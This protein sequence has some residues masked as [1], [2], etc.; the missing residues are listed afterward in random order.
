METVEKWYQITL[1]YIGRKINLLPHVAIISKSALGFVQESSGGQGTGTWQALHSRVCPVA[2][3]PPGART[4]RSLLEEVWAP[5]DHL[6]KPRTTSS[7]SNPAHPEFS[8]IQSWFSENHTWDSQL[9][10][11][12]SVCVCAQNMFLK[13]LNWESLNKA[14]LYLILPSFKSQIP[15]NDI[16]VS[17]L[18]SGQNKSLG[19]SKSSF[20]GSETSLV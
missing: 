7:P 1:I 6:G 5:P 11:C 3:G 4:P 20:T 18:N 13:A 9:C 12:V 15:N 10:L 2:W 17:S 16:T 14:Q 19:F 8:L